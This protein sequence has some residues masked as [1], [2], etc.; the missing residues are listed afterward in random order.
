VPRRPARSK[1][2]NR[3]VGIVLSTS[4]LFFNFNRLL[5]SLTEF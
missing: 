4:Q 5:Y 1:L 3:A 2:Q